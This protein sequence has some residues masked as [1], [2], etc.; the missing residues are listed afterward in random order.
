MARTPLEETFPVEK[1]NPLA[2]AEGNAKKPIYRMHKWWARRLGSVF[3]MVVLAALGRPGS[4]EAELCAAFD[5]ETDLGGKLVLDPFMGGGTTVVEALRLGCRVVGVDI[6]PVAWFV[7]KKEVEPVE[8]A[9]LDEAF[10]QLERTA[11]ARIKPYYQT[12]CPA[13]HP[14]ETMYVFWVKSAECA[15]CGER[16]R[17]FPNYEL[18]RRDESQVSCCPAC[19]AIVTTPGYD[20]QTTCP[21][22]GTCFDPRAG[23]AGRG[24]FRCGDCGEEGT[25]LGAVRGRGGPLEEE[26]HALEG[27]CGECGRFFKKLDAADHALWERARAEFERCRERLPF[28][29][30][31]IATEGRSDPRPVNHGYAHYHDMFNARQLL[32][33]SWLLEEIL[34]LSG[35]NARELM[36]TAFSDCL[37]ANTMFCK[38]EVA[39]HKISVFFGLHA[40]HPIERPTENNVW[41]THFG[42][43]TFSRCF[44]KVR[45]A[46]VGAK[47]GAGAGAKGGEQAATDGPEKPAAPR[48]VAGYEELLQTPRG[49]LLRCQSSENLD[50]LPD[51]VVDAVIT[52]PPYFDNVQYSELADFFHVWLREGLKGRYPWFERQ[53][54]A[55]GRELLKNDRLGKTA[56]F[57]NAGLQAVFSEC[58]RVLKDDGLL[59]FTFHHNRPWAWEG[60]ARLLLEAGFY[61]SNSPIVRSEGK[62][63]FHSSA[64]NIKYDAVLVCRKTPAPAPRG[65]GAVDAAGANGGSGDGA[66]DTALEAAIL[67]DAVHWA[68]RTLA[69]GMILGDADLF[70]ILMGQS[71]KHA[72]RAE[73][74][75]GAA[76]GGAA[77]GGAALEQPIADLLERMGALT[78]EVRAMAERPVAPQLPEA[79][80]TPGAAREG[81]A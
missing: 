41:G 66:A 67:A 51:G 76:L 36:L 65:T 63:G 32:C 58:R 28:P 43:G 15:G 11:A 23:V 18:S 55:H 57:F 74:L 40:Y 71:L 45:R 7:S 81:A 46:K 30:Q 24:K 80:E 69:S 22:C 9:E 16:V 38:Y 62:S 60:L 34:K 39:W 35:E 27:Y 48:L 10:A 17:L 31:A 47:V 29:R 53:S 42:R 14:A 19:L 2:L 72:T 68:R 49:A 75:G 26:A 73:A 3:R 12:T 70:A 64:G 8:A 52:D 1:I 77:P 79:G 21:A 37:D 59:V 78:G 50:F 5:G 20:P 13:G 61:V 25:V 44:Q 56:E 6:N 4:G 54:A 33:L